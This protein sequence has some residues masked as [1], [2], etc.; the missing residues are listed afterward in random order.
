MNTIVETASIYCNQ[1]GKQGRADA[2]FCGACG[3]DLTAGLEPAKVVQLGQAGQA[4]QLNQMGNL[5]QDGCSEEG[6]QG[7]VSMTLGMAWI[8][9]FV[10]L[11]IW[12][13][14]A[15]IPKL[16]LGTLV[17]LACGF[18]MTRY[19]MRGVM[20]FHPVYNTVANVFSAK[21]WMF[22]LWPLSMLILLFKLT[23]NSAL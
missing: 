19:V 20:E 21:I 2:R 13:G 7:S 17:Y 5:E 16:P 18:V 23:V 15:F 4:G 10:A 8:I 14:V 9:Y 12:V 1:C 6:L 3:H 11:L 22:L